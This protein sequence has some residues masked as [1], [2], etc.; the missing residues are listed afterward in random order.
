MNKEKFFF[1]AYLP[2]VNKV[3]ETGTSIIK[4]PNKYSIIW[5]NFINF[6]IYVNTPL[7][8]AL[9]VFGKSNFLNFIGGVIS[10]LFVIDVGILLIF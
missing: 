8:K 5:C 7:S 2:K 9:V 4:T 10:Y 6:F 1:N 3:Y